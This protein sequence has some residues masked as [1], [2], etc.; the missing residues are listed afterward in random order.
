M[1]PYNRFYAPKFHLD[2]LIYSHYIRY[3]HLKEIILNEFSNTP[4]ADC[5]HISL[6]IDIYSIIKPFY[7]RQDFAVD[8]KERYALASGIINMAAHYR[9]YFRTRHSTKTDIYLIS[10]F[11]S[12]KYLQRLCNT[13]KCGI[14]FAM[15]E[16]SNY[17]IENIKVLNAI[18]PYLP[19]IYFRHYD[20]TTTSAAILDIMNYN[21]SH[22]NNNP[23]IIISK[24]ILNYQL[25]TFRPVKTIIIRPKKISVQKYEG[26]DTEERSYSINKYNL[27]ATYL[28]EKSKDLIKAN[29]SEIMNNRLKMV[30]Q[31]NPELL[32]IL[33]AI[34]NVPE[35][36]LS[37]I[38]QMPS[39]I[40]ILYRIFVEDR[41][42]LNQYNSDI[43]Y[44][45]DLVKDYSKK[46]ID[47]I[48]IKQRFQ[49]IDMIYLYNM[50]KSISME[51]YEKVD[52]LYNPKMVKDV[53]EKFFSDYPLD[54]NV[55]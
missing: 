32:S 46:Q 8:D 36:G 35:Y 17:V 33:M 10:S 13:Y 29:N 23:N 39:A 22:G 27:M 30:N 44:I 3:D 1:R 20:V 50:M 25:V 34:T 14:N 12:N 31:L 21:I 9:E 47:D 6:F 45:I 7:K 26:I 18:V 24:D 5:T 4:E 16:V 55:L 53:N 38:I 51:L 54:L 37:S 40:K 41:L 15:E 52:D 28:L 2:S 19:N 42:A 43:S 11:N 49:V 48:E